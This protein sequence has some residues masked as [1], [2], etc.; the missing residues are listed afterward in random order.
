MAVLGCGAVIVK[1]P[2]RFT[3]ENYNDKNFMYTFCNGNGRAAVVE[4]WQ[5]PLHRIPHCKTYEGGSIVPVSELR[6]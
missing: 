1:F 5:Y 2:D 3:D 4:Y 6:T